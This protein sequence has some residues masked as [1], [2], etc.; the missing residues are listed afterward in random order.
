[1]IVL[2]A[3]A[4]AVG[5]RAGKNKP[6]KLTIAKDFFSCQSTGWKF[7]KFRSD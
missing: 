2:I 6:E 7:Q 5:D 4:V 3:C 1:M